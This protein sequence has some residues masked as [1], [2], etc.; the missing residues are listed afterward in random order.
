MPAL[1]RLARQAV[2]AEVDGQSPPKPAKATPP[3]PV[4]V[5][6]ERYGRI[7]GCRGSLET[8]TSSLE[9]E[10][11]EAARA[12]ARHD[13]RYA[14]L[15]R[16]DLRGFLVGVTVVERRDPIQ[17]VEGLPPADGLVLTSGGRTGVVLPWEGRDPHVRLTWAYRKAGVNEGAKVLLFRL[18]AE[19]SR[20]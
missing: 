11:V 16:S 7:L 19:R 15:K 1:I 6:I 12:A 3:R 5:T 20:G 9:A 4:F 14:P 10:V 8:R 17:T 13:P 2:V 18:I